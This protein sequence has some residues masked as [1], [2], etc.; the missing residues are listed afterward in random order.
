[1]SLHHQVSV[2]SCLKSFKQF[3]SIFIRAKKSSSK[4]NINLTFREEILILTLI[5]FLALVTIPV[6]MLTKNNNNRIEKVRLHES[7]EDQ[8]LRS[9]YLMYSI[10]ALETHRR[11]R[12]SSKIEFSN[13]IYSPMFELKELIK[14]DIKVIQKHPRRFMKRTWKRFTYVNNSTL[15]SSSLNIPPRVDW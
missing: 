5:Y 15:K 9:E 6:I 12:N 10:S 3:R 11:I 8:K 7:L 2:V 4:M 1:M 14:V 13:L